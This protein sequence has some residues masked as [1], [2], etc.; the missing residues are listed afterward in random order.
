MFIRLTNHTACNR[1]SVHD[2]LYFNQFLIRAHFSHVSNVKYIKTRIYLYNICFI[3]QIANLAQF[4]IYKIYD[5]IL[6]LFWFI[7]DQLKAIV[8]MDILIK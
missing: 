3:S 4:T 2:R 1:K 6:I 7:L 8:N 5:S